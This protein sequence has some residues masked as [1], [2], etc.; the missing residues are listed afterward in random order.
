MR[1]AEGELPCRQ[2]ALAGQ[3]LAEAASP[4]TAA[5][6]VDSFGLSPGHAMG[7][8]APYTATEPSVLFELC[9]FSL[10]KVCV[11]YGR[12][13]KEERESFHS[14]TTPVNIL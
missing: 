8:Y 14:Q 7:C 2:A 13:Q 6:L 3:W 12:I 4:V 5:Q 9:F 1:K 10:I 11:H